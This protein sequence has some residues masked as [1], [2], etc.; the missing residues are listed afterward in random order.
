MCGRYD[1]GKGATDEKMAALI[2]HQRDGAEV[3]RNVQ[4]RGDPSRRY[5][6]GRDRAQ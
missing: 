1:F 2:T 5:R 3:S 4:N 6:P